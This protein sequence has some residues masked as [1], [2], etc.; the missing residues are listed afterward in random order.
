MIRAH[1]VDPKTIRSRRALGVVWL[2]RVEYGASVPAISILRRVGLM[3]LQMTVG[4][5]F[6]FAG[7]AAASAE[8]SWPVPLSISTDGKVFTQRPVNPILIAIERFAPGDVD[9]RV[10]WVRNDS[11]QS[12]W[13]WSSSRLIYG[14]AELEPYVYIEGA[15]RPA[16]ADA[17]VFRPIDKRRCNTLVPSRLLAPGEVVSLEFAAG[18]VPQA[19]NNTRGTSAEFSVRF[20]LVQNRGQ[21][22]VDGCVVP[23]TDPTV[24]PTAGRTPLAATGAFDFFPRLVAAGGFV[25]FGVVVLVISWHAKTR[26]RSF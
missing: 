21:G 16:V 4:I 14:D 12:A 13:L 10:L 5:V 25:I 7:A 26:K 24:S 19:P 17:A 20:G 1:A 15:Y 3:I 11:A 18:I 9:Q 6:C 2:E 8:D 22:G 23:A